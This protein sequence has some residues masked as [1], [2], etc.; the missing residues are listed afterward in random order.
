[1][2]VMQFGMALFFGLKKVMLNYMY[3]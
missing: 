2:K 1:M 3:I